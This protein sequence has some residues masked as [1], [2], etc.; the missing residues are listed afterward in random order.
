[1]PI[2][3]TLHED[4][5]SVDTATLNL[6]T[7]LKHL[8]LAGDYAGQLDEVSS[9]PPVLTKITLD[10]EFDQPLDTVSWPSTLQELSF[11]WRFNKA[12]DRVTWPR[13]LKTLSLGGSFN[14]PVERVV[15]PERLENLSFNQNSEQA[16]DGLAF[17]STMN[18]LTVGRAPK[19]D[20]EALPPG[21]KLRRYEYYTL[22]MESTPD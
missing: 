5:Q 22:M 8:K 13:N 9:W 3:E 6:A 1:M 12:L 16:I 7:G 10:G 4:F 21:V 17:P 19:I 11:G 20:A 14:Q 2:K 18:T 15:L